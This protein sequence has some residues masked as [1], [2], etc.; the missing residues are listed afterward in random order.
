MIE[1]MIYWFK[2]KYRQI[3]RVIEILPLI[4]NSYD[5]DYI[6]AI[7][8]FKFQLGKL[9]DFLESDKSITVGSNQRAQKI[10]T[11]IRLMDK[12]Y[13]EEYGMEYLDKVEKLY[14]R[15][16][17][18]RIELDETDKKG[19]KLYRIEFR[20]EFARD[21]EHQKEIDEI[22]RKLMFQSMDKQKRAH[23]LLWEFIEHNIQGWWD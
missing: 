2:R 11:A 17:F 7:N 8:L 4:W 20:N 13:K 16:H 14:G 22:S 1:K 21:K 5:F 9:A 12:V 18:D 10:R 19:E 3:N 15:T 6:Y 23:K